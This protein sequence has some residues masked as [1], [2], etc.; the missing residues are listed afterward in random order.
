MPRFRSLVRSS[1]RSFSRSSFRSVPEDC[2]M[3]VSRRDFTRLLAMSGG[4]AFIP[5]S[6]D[7]VDWLKS[8]MDTP[9]PKTPAVA[10]E[11]FWKE[12]RA[13]FLMPPDVAFIN[14]ANICPTS[15]PVLEALERTARQFEG[16]PSQAAKAKL[17]E[18]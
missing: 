2:K 10:D 17:F 11:P 15:L 14:A 13:R 5:A 4:A 18:A 7:R 12:V 6:R 16:N 3:T 8:L 1:F 9:L